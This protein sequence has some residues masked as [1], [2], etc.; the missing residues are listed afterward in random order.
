M[1]R[2][3]MNNDELL[4][5]LNALNRILVAKNIK[6]EIALFGGAVM[7]LVFNVRP[8]TADIDAVFI[9][10]SELYEAAK[11]VANDPKMRD[12]QLR[13]DWL[14]DGVKGFLSEN[15]DVLLFTQLSNIDIYTPSP[16]YMFAMKALSC[17][18]D[19][20]NEMMDLRFLIHFLHI[21][22]LEQAKEIIY[23]YYPVNRILPKTFY[24]IMEMLSP[25]C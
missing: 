17:R 18:T 25:P 9:P 2:R 11:E 20:E 1:H 21:T 22:S 13:E 15:H 10:K 7:C 3:I 23:K 16:E 4:K 6:A 19:N 14:N 5:C 12:L 24:T 8:G